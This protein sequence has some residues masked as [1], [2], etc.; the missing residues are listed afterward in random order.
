MLAA[1]R[2]KGC[3]KPQGCINV[4][5]TSNTQNYENHFFCDVS[6]MIVDFLNHKDLFVSP[7]S[8]SSTLQGLWLSRL[9]SSSFIIS[10]M[11]YLD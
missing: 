10:G 9:Y 4:I 5:S 6:Q 8:I 11:R 1:I 3:Q 2:L 7:V